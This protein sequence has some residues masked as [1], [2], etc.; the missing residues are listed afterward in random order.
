MEKWFCKKYEEL[1][2][3]EIHDL[4]ALRAAV[5]VVEQD[6]IYQDIDGK[7]LS[8]H[9]ILGFTEKDQLFAYSRILAP[10]K[11]YSSCVAIGRIVIELNYRK[12]NKGH[13]LVHY[14]IEKAKALYPSYQIKISAQLHLSDFYESHGFKKEGKSYLE[15]GIPHI[16]MLLKK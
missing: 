10:G 7:D 3:K 15:D 8:A 4:F 1:T 14:S 6:C 9:H 16:A 5:F 13:E 2:K 11:G 12:K